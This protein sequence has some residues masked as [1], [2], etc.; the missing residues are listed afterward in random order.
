MFEITY[1][2]GFAPGLIYL[3]RNRYGKQA[4]IAV[5]DRS[6]EGR[7]IVRL[8]PITSR[9]SVSDA[10]HLEIAAEAV[11]SL[12]DAISRC[13]EET[14]ANATLNDLAD[15]LPQGAGMAATGVNMP[16]LEVALHGPARSGLS[17]ALSNRRPPPVFGTIEEQ[18]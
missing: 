13:I 14:V 15:D 16:V 6:R 5:A 3:G 4:G 11:P 2:N 1:P 8:Y 12:V 9:G 18:P 7:K 10:C 17:I